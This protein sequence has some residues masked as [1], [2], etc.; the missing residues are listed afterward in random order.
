MPSSLAD[1]V[2]QV[3]DADYEDDDEEE[4]EKNV[5]LRERLR[6]YLLKKELDAIRSEI[7]EADEYDVNN[8]WPMS[9]PSPPFANI[10]S[11]SVSHAF[12]RVYSRY[13]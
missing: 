9:K 10:Y 1:D 7:E 12:S 5:F 2:R 8:Q 13:M 3:E 6:Q 4:Y 11:G